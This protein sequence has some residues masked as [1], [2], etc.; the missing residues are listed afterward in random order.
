MSLINTKGNEFSVKF[1]QQTVSLPPDSHVR[2][3]LTPT[4][5]N[6]AVLHGEALVEQ[7]SGPTSVGKN[8]TM[9]FNLA[10][11][12]PAGDCQERRGAT[13]RQVG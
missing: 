8:K 6:L 2:L 1:G 11:R 4:E 9:T 5:A 7:P 10:A 3:Q 12:K 13:T